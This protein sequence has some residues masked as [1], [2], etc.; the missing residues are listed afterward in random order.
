M[1]SRLDSLRTAWEGITKVRSNRSIVMLF[2]GNCS[3]HV[4]PRRCFASP[5]EA[6]AFLAYAQARAGRAVRV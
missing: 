6:K 2:L 5:A 1:V 3:A 4:V